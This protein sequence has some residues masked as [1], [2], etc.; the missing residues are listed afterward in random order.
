MGAVAAEEA[1]GL[2]DD[3]SQDHVG[4]AEGGDPGRDV[5]QRPLGVRAPGDRRLRSLE[6]RDEPGIGD[7][8]RRLVGEA[9]EHRLVDLVEGVALAPVDLDGAERTLIAD[10]RGDDEIADVGGR[11]E[12]VGLRRVDEVAGQVVAGGDAPVARPSP[13]RP[14]PRRCGAGSCARTSRCVSDRPAS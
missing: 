14:G 13:C 11:G 4:L 9:A 5:A 2:L 8:D 7:R 1:L 12:L 6:L 3:A 10:D